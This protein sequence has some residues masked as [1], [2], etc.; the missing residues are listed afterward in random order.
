MKRSSVRNRPCKCRSVKRQAG[1]TLL[2][3]I[4]AITIFATS[5]LGLYAWINSMMIGTAR[6]TEISVESTDV[7]N[8]V[9]YL[10][11]VN[12]SATPSGS[13]QLGDLT[14]S[15]T[16]ELVEPPRSGRLV[17]AWELGLYDL[18]V[19]L[20]RPGYPDRRLRLRLSF[21]QLPLHRTGKKRPVHRRTPSALARSS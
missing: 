2:E 9:D 10:S 5:A 21:L 20:Q 14:L 8:A 15:W 16:S 13:Q 4:V 1:F 19:T 11:M 7:D 18:D 17:P 3:A 6:F 12:P